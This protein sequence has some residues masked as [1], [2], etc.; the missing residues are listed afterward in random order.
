MNTTTQAR[1]RQGELRAVII[2]GEMAGTK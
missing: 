2:K 1:G